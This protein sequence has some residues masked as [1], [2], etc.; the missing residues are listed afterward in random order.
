MYLRSFIYLVLLCLWTDLTDDNDENK[1][2]DK[3]RSKDVM[4]TEKQ[5]PETHLIDV[6][7]VLEQV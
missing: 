2:E 1:K 6:E 3:P 5:H 4:L 7:S